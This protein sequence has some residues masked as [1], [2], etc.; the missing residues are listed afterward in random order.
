[1]TDDGRSF[2]ILLEI[3]AVVLLLALACAGAF[4]AVQTRV[5]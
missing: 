1:M 4:D 5:D 3:G 2:W